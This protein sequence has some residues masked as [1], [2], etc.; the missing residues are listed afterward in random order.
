M[1]HWYVNECSSPHKPSQVQP[2]FYEY[3]AGSCTVW[4]HTACRQARN[5]LA[6]RQSP[7]V[8]DEGET[9]TNSGRSEVPQA[10]DSHHR[11]VT[12]TALLS[13]TAAVLPPRVDQAAPGRASGV[14]SLG[15][16]APP[17]APA[18][19]TLSRKLC[20]LVSASGSPCAKLRQPPPVRA[21][22]TSR[23]RA[24]PHAA[25]AKAPGR[26]GLSRWPSAAHAQ[27]CRT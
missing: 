27:C 5:V 13:H 2:I 15:G 11:A 12:C 16:Q 7:P 19:P 22:A 4:I 1:R 26:G 17:A 3:K 10:A 9:R 14:Q 20:V 23:A 21:C 8:L 18:A 6:G 25:A 24:S